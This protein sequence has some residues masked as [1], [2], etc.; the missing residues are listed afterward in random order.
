MAKRDF[1]KREIILP[2]ELIEPLS[3]WH[4]GMDAIYSLHSWGSSK[5]VSLNMIQKAREELE[6]DLR[7]ARAKGTFDDDP[8]ALEELEMLIGELDMIESSPREFSARE[9]GMDMD[10]D[11]YEYDSDADD[12]GLDGL[13]YG[14]HGEPSDRQRA[15]RD[16]ERGQQDARSEL[17]NVRWSAEDI[18]EYLASTRSQGGDYQ[19]GYNEVMREHLEGLGGLGA[20]LAGGLG[21]WNP[22]R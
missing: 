20:G 16:Y 10:E 14:G 1:Y 8:E 13:G 18:R 19:R 21:F 7:K 12:E 11:E 17:R 22:K 2:H 15:R 9:S 4:N 6:R 3:H 5:L